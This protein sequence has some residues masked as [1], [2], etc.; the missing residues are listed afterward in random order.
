MF[1]GEYIALIDEYDVAFLH[2]FSTEH[3]QLFLYKMK[4]VNTL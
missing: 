4:L 2:L 1:F 3:L